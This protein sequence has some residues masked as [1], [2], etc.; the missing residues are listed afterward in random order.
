MAFAGY[1][2][3]DKVILVTGSCGFIGFWLCQKI[4]SLYKDAFIIGFDNMNE[5]YDVML[6]RY[7]LKILESFSNFKF[8][9]GDISDN[10]KVSLVFNEYKP[11]VVVNL[12]AQAGVRYSITNPEAYVQS[13][14]VGFFNILE[15]C[16]KSMQGQSSVEQLVYASSSS[17]YGYNEK[18]PYSTDDKVEEPASFYA[19]TKKSNELFAYSYSKLYG[20]PVTGLRFF[21]V[22]GPAGRPDMAYFSFTD[23]I[24]NGEP[25]QLYNNGEMMRDFTY[26]DDVIHAIIA[27]INKGKEEVKFK[28]PYKVYNVGSSNPVKITYLVD[29]LESCLIETGVI[30]KKAERIFMPMQS[31]D[32]YKTF[33]DMSDFETD[34][35][36]KPMTDMKYGLRTFCKWYANIYKSGKYKEGLL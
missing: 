35:G 16:R 36:F 12:A 28:E 6:K 25:V 8:I 21:T 27:I 7:R 31:G 2:V 5:Y 23:K 33:A 18:I 17:V 34:F 4:L 29:E 15:A 26:I 22:Y 14:I 10:D 20:I 32:V 11:T 9:T 3:N 13:N 30:E 19:A 24:V 1:K